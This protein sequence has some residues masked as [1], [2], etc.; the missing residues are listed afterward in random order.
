MQDKTQAP[1]WNYASAQF[2]V[3]VEFFEQPGHRG[4]PA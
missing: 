3:D 4:A 2:F 1:T